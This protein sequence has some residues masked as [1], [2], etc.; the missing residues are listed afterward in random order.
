MEE[1]VRILRRLA[2]NNDGV[3]TRRQALA[4]GVDARVW[5]GLVQAGWVRELSRGVGFVDA[6][7]SS[8]TS[9][10]LLRAGLAAYGKHAV[11]VLHSAANVHG[12]CGVP[13]VDS[14]HV[15]ARNSV[16][17][18][19]SLRTVAHRRFLKADEI[20]IVDGFPVTTPMRT[21]A[22]L[23][24]R[25]PAEDGI[26]VLDSALRQSLVTEGE[27]AD[28]A[29]AVAGRPG[30]AKVRGLLAIA[31]ARA[32]SPLESRV[33]LD[34]VRGGVAPDE[35]QHEVALP[36][37]GVARVD[38]AW[39]TGLRPV[40][41]EADG[42]RVHSRPDALFRDRARANELALAGALVLRFTWHD[43]LRRGRV[44]ALVRRAFQV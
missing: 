39:L 14:V 5:R 44:A 30:A 11:A 22:D 8:P 20:S 1:P 41:G 43:T 29:R 34:C 12:M 21:L 13:R 36:G 26:A 33:R 35:L 40:F 38:L 7:R 3:V 28:V 18:S 15:A 9:R 10:T 25:L 27:L 24:P 31:D 19:G 23:L 17:R 6:D 4:A 16:T 32:E 2:W 42:T 37:G